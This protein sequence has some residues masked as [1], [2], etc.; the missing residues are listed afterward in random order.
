M[1]EVQEHQ[2]LG[3]LLAFVSGSVGGVG[4]WLFLRQVPLS[5]R[6]HAAGAAIAGCC[7]RHDRAA[8]MQLVP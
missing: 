6:R 4:V 5:R 3:C 7:C 2:R 1:H 8:L